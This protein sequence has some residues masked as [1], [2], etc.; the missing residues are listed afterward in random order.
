[1]NCDLGSRVY[2]PPSWY[3]GVFRRSVTQNHAGILASFFPVGLLLS[4]IVFLESSYGPGA[5]SEPWLVYLICLSTIGAATAWPTYLTVR[6]LPDYQIDGFSIVVMAV[7]FPIWGTI[8][9]AVGFF[10]LAPFTCTAIWAF[11]LG[12]VLS[13]RRAWHF[14]LIHSAV[15][16]VLAIPLIWLASRN[17]YDFF[18]LIFPT[19]LAWHVAH[20]F[21]L[22]LCAEL[23]REDLEHLRSRC[24]RCGY[25]R[26]GLTPGTACPECGLRTEPERHA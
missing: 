4:A 9:V 16:L 2:K 11:N 21:T 18:S 10:L 8:G 12:L 26:D 23:H 25:S 19:L 6:N 14:F 15:T 5:S 3:P 1:M 22:G 20:P 13:R 7:L 24:G 17:L